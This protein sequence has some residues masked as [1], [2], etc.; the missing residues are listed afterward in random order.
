MTNI[1]QLIIFIFK[2]ITKSVRKCLLLGRSH[3]T[4]IN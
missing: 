2:S 1:T 3:I 4:R